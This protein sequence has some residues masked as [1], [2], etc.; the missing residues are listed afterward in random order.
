MGG[1]SSQVGVPLGPWRLSGGSFQVFGSCRYL[2]LHTSIYYICMSS[3][4]HWVFK[5]EKHVTFLKASTTRWDLW[6]P[7]APGAPV[8]QG[9][10]RRTPAVLGDHPEAPR[11]C[12]GRS[13]G[14]LGEQ[15]ELKGSIRNY[16]KNNMLSIVLRAPHWR[17]RR[18]KGPG[19]VPCG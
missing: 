5:N 7:S 2:C 14:R 6:A 4:D 10:S 15:R 3:L 17:H 9:A 1:K 8:G 19:E 12:G 16:F 13:R 18:K 11:L